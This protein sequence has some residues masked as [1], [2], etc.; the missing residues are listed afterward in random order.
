M[1]AQP[2]TLDTP[3]FVVPEERLIPVNDYP[4]RLLDIPQSKMFLIK[5]SLTTYKKNFGADAPTYDA[6]Q[7]D[8][9]A[10][11]HDRRVRAARHPVLLD[12]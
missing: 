11:R 10:R 5:Q 12:A 4:S 8:G 7:G 2:V 3:V 6:S 1:T 9:G